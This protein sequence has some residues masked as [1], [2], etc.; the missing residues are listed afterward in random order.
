MGASGHESSTG[1]GGILRERDTL[2]FDFLRFVESLHRCNQC[3][4]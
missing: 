2:R 3:V 4:V 1:W